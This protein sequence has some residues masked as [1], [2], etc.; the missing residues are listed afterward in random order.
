MG[1]PEHW[2]V[3]CFG[4]QSSNFGL[5]VSGLLGAYLYNP[6]QRHAPLKLIKLCTD[7]SETAPISRTYD[8]PASN[9]FIYRCDGLGV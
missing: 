9:G 6:L 7:R 5:F 4:L 1:A 8:T 2:G 3:A